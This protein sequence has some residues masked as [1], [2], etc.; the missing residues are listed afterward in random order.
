M[1]P[2]APVAE[3]PM[4][5]P[6]DPNSSSACVGARTAPPLGQLWGVKL[7]DCPDVV[8]VEHELPY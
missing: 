5:F 7:G 3:E 4:T 1:M 8:T 6:G 2:A